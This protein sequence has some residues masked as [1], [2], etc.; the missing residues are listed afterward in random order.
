[1]VIC[2]TNRALCKDNFLKRIESICKAGPKVYPFAGK[3]FG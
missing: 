2:V 3:R 1:M